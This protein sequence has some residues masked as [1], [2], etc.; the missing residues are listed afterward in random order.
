VKDALLNLKDQ[1]VYVV[2][3]AGHRVLLVV[4]RLGNKVMTKLGF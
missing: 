2:L 4:G 3:S 1:V